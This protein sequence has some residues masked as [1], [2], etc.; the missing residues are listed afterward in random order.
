[1]DVPYLP[2]HF[3]RTGAVHVFFASLSTACFPPAALLVAWSAR[4]DARWQSIHTPLVR[5]AGACFV[6]APVVFFTGNFYV[7]LFGLVQRIYTVLALAWL[8]L[9]A[10]RLRSAAAG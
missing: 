5:L 2:F 3:T 7:S 8:L 9:A 6:V 4:L 10:N 1:M